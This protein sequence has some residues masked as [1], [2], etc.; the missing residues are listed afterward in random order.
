MNIQYTHL[1]IA[2]AA[3]SICASSA[4]ADDELRRSATKLEEEL[5]EEEAEHA[6]GEAPSSANEEAVALA[7]PASNPA[8]DPHRETLRATIDE[9]SQKRFLHGFRLG[10]M[11]LANIHGPANGEPGTESLAEKHG[12]RSPH[13]FLIGYEVTWRIVGHEWLNV[14]LL[15]S[16]VVTGLEQSKFFPSANGLIGF[17]FAETFQAGVGV[18]AAPTK[19]KP[20]H[21][22][23]A[24]GLTPRVG[25]FYTPIH[26][27]FVPDVDS[28]H[29]LGVT[30]GVNF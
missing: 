26:V 15:G 22:V 17:E 29:R 6:P 13:Q 2:I 19:D 7:P 20:L 10:Y 21:M 18:N 3:G 28:Q 11:F 12:I 27:F 14:M 30:V 24:A 5:E 1:A 23:L 9:V 25:D 4:F 8:P 16:T